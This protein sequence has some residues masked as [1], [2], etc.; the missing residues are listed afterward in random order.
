M[1]AKRKSKDVSD[2]SAVDSF[3][4][5]H[6]PTIGSLGEVELPDMFKRCIIAWRLLELFEIGRLLAATESKIGQKA[7]VTAGHNGGPPLGTV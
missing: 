1:T 2:V 5:Y 4:I 6:Q 3:G 7:A